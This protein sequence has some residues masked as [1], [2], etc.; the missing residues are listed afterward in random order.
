[1]NNSKH[2][3]G[4]VAIGLHWIAAL[5]VLGLFGLGFWMVDLGYYD[6]WYKPAPALHKS[7]GI[8]LFGLMLFRLV[9]RLLQPQPEALPTHS[10][11]EKI[12]GHLM[13]LILYFM[14]FTIMLTGYLISTADGRGI[15][16]FE[17][18]QVPGFGSFIENQEDL[19]GAIHKYAA[20]SLIVLVTL[21]AVAALKH[22]FIDKDNTLK[23]MLGKPN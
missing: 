22:H 8:S 1:M 10:P 23:R 2:H 3:Y 18:F 9:W 4:W 6:Q 21:H 12:A 14:L 15:E 19:A 16:V 5:V 13:H 20:Y 7:I 11:V 17:L